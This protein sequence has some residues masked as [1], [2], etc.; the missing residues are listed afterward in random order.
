MGAAAELYS[1]P[2]LQRKMS[3]QV[4]N[5]VRV[6]CVTHVGHHLF[7]TLDSSNNLATWDIVTGE[8]ITSLE[9]CKPSQFCLTILVS[10]A[11]RVFVMGDSCGNLFFVEHNEGTNLRR[12]CFYRKAHEDEFLRLQAHAHIFVA[13]SYDLTVSVWNSTQRSCIRRFPT[14]SEHPISLDIDQNHLILAG[15]DELHIYRND[16][17]QEFH[18]IKVIRGTYLSDGRFYPIV[19][20]LTKEFAIVTGGRGALLHLLN[21]RSGSVVARIKLP[22][23]HLLRMD[24]T[25]D[26]RLL[27]TACSDTTDDGG[28]TLF[29]V[30]RP[31]L[32]VKAIK[33]YTDAKF[34]H[35]FQPKKKRPQFGRR[36]INIIL[37]FSVIL[38]LFPVWRR[39]HMS[40]D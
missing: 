17:D 10:V 4:E 13:S 1:I 31:P 35:R 5:P 36:T 21:L 9:V 7:A 19:R 32:L 28:H 2:S 27:A 6:D 39:K 29:L 14:K 40:T 24:I 34:G 11:E 37:L 30:R 22:Y 16:N 8:K 25:A 20:L 26:G 3:F 38:G 15:K 23:E 18:L 12:S 33:S